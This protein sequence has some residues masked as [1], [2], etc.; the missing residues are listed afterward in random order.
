MEG[1]TR[2]ALSR[3]NASH[4]IPPEAARTSLSSRRV[5][6]RSVGSSRPSN[7]ELRASSELSAGQLPCHGRP[8][9]YLSFPGSQA[10]V[11]YEFRVFFRLTLQT[12]LVDPGG[13]TGFKQPVRNA[14]PFPV[15]A[16]QTGPVLFPL[17]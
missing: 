13:S 14:T 17:I 11:N 1:S 10:A 6:L 16:E 4:G 7:A 2:Y 15:P 8:C 3:G 5:S 12:S 9:L